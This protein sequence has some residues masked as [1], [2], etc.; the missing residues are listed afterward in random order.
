MN[1]IDKVSVIALTLLGL[2]QTL[3]TPFFYDS[4]TEEAVWFFGSG[5]ALMFL[6]FLN[7]ARRQSPRNKPILAMSATA[8]AIGVLFAMGIVAVHTVPQAVIALFLMVCV[9]MATIEQLTAVV[10]GAELKDGAE[11]KPYV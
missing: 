10:E 4:L 1:K 8:N 7:L 2:T 3:L 5:L 6:G 9:L 11:R